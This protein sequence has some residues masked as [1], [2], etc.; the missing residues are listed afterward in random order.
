MF[1]AAGAIGFGT[2]SLLG[3]QQP[4]PSQDL[5]TPY[6]DPME[7]LQLITAQRTLDSIHADGQLHPIEEPLRHELEAIPRVI[8]K[9][10][11]RF[12][13][14]AS[15]PVQIDEDR[16]TET[17]QDLIDLIQ[18]RQ[19]KWD[20]AGGLLRIERVL[21]K[22]KEILDLAQKSSPSIVLGRLHDVYLP[23][24]EHKRLREAQRIGQANESHAAPLRRSEYQL[25]TS[26]A[27]MT[28]LLIFIGLKLRPGP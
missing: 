12:A 11:V 2:A 6:L 27:L 22:R 7:V 20:F 19:L 4:A 3:F 8:A 15:P 26:L 5:R 28:I 9:D 14:K 13:G 17:I 24:F 25:L 21:L 1:I 16:S 18:D 10:F 23:Y